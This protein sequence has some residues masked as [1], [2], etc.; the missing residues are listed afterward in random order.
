LHVGINLQAE[1]SSGLE[2]GAGTNKREAH[3]GRYGRLG[4]NMGPFFTFRKTSC[5]F[6]FLEMLTEPSQQT[7]FYFA[8]R[9][10]ASHFISDFF[11]TPFLYV[12]K[13]TDDTGCLFVSIC[14]N[15]FQSPAVYLPLTF[16]ELSLLCTNIRP[17]FIV[18][19]LVK[20]VRRLSLIKAFIT[21]YTTVH[22]WKQHLL[23]H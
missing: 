15:S 17:K 7:L 18:I 23:T 4:L 9:A 16:E 11:S 14:E 22:Y 13:T 12:N 19:Y 6:S 1:T 5:V 21:V 10:Y 8:R 3:A 2:F 20:K